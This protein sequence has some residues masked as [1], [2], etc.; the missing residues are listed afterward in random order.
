MDATTSNCKHQ[1]Y[2]MTAADSTLLLHKRNI[3]K[4]LFQTKA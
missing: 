2:G 4:Q 1:A 3:K